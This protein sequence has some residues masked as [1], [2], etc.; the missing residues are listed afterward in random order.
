MTNEA[1]PKVQE[2]LLEMARARALRSSS[3]SSVFV[4]VLLSGIFYGQIAQGWSVPSSFQDV[5]L[6]LPTTYDNPRSSNDLVVEES[7][8]SPS[9]Q[10]SADSLAT[11]SSSRR[12]WISASI[13]GPIGLLATTSTSSTA[14]AAVVVVSAPLAFPYTNAQLKD[15]I[16]S[17]IVDRQFLATGQLT[18]NIY[19]DTAL[20]TDEID[21]YGID[22]WI[23]GTQRLFVGAGS[24]VRLVGPV[25]VSDSD[26]TFRF[27]EDL[28][29]NIPLLRPVVK[30][31]GTVRLERDKETGYITSYRE[32][33]DQDT[34]TV[35]KSA[36][37]GGSSK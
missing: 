11:K 26:I 21:T 10:L 37:F 8:T 16:K 5:E 30:L 7:A 13:L 1:D 19:S 3:L 23:Q 28:M 6:S 9:L 15:I 31:T 25:D 27:D 35:L 20:F 14:A 32:F 2:S 17:D 12:Q 33:W 18:R 36:Q 24:S 34:L 4:L 22:Q 29:F